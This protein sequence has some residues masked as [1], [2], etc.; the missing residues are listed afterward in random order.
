MHLYKLSGILLIVPI[1]D[2]ALA[3]PV[4]VQEKRQARPDMADIPKYPVTMLGK[5]G[6]IEEEAGERIE[7]LLPKVENYFG[8]PEESSAAEGSSSSA[9][10][11]AGQV[12]T[13]APPP[14][15]G[16]STRPPYVMNTG[17]KGPLSSSM[18]PK[19]FHSDNIILDLHAS[20]P[21]PADSGHRVVMEEPPSPTRASSTGRVSESGV[22]SDDGLPSPTRLSSTVSESGFDSAG[23]PPSSSVPLT[24]PRRASMS[25]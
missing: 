12:S 3:V 25:A 6:N 20:Q 19:W 10:S 8:K 14:N 13:N 2:F 5:R 18:N 15:P 17:L 4:L 1:V 7:T 16:P 21:I 23:S 9:P 11:E 22:E 24:D